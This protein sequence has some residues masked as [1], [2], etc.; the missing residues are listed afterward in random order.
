M[1][2]HK[3]LGQNDMYF[4]N[5]SHFSKFLNVALLFTLLC[6]EPWYLAQLCTY[7]GAIFRKDIVYLYMI[8][9]KLQI[10]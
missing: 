10:F 4:W 3:I 7:I 6:L 8:F 5:G 9:L 1:Y 2:A